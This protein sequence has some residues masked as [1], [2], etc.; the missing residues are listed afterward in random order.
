MILKSIKLKN[1]RP[2]RGPEEIK[3]ATGEKNI[4]IIHDLL[5]LD[6]S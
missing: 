4:T 2:Y 5:T 3:F 6:N 1:F